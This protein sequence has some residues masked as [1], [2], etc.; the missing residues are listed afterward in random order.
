M[1]KHLTN[2]ITSRSL[3]PQAL[4]PPPCQHYSFKKGGEGPGHRLYNP[5]LHM[6]VH[7]CWTILYQNCQFMYLYGHE[8]S[9][10][11]YK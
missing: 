11:S 5:L 9:T 10:F 4:L 7:V 6:Q 8:N 3:V 1:A 2:Q